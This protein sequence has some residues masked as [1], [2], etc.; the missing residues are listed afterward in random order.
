[1]KYVLFFVLSAVLLW[2]GPGRAQTP[3]APVPPAGPP[4]SREPPFSRDVKLADVRM[5]DACILPDPAT[6][7]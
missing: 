1:M 7:T 4:R 2:G 6:Q 5:R 3:E